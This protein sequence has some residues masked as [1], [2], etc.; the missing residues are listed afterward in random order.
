[1]ATDCCDAG[2][3]VNVYCT[4][5]AGR[6][7]LGGFPGCLRLFTAR[8]IAP[9]D[10]TAGDVVVVKGRELPVRTPGMAAAASD[11]FKAGAVIHCDIDL[12]RELSFFWQGG[13]NGGVVLSHLSF[14]EQFAGYYDEYGDKV[15]CKTIDLGVIPYNN[16]KVVPHNISNLKSVVND[17]F[18]WNG[19][20]HHYIG[21]RTGTYYTIIEY[22]AS[23]VTTSVNSPS[24]V[25]HALTTIYYTCTDR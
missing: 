7:T 19:N 5:D 18:R 11:I 2:K 24:A 9:A 6:F 13:G 23:N 14:E 10:Y 16:V 8:F 12:D 4:Y 21:N 3:I 22:T 17:S 15:Y 25:I 20:G 1:M